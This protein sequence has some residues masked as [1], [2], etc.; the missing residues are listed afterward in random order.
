[1]QEAWNKGQILLTVLTVLQLCVTFTLSVYKS[2]CS[3]VLSRFSHFWYFVTLWTVAHQALL[4]IGFFRQEY[5]S[6]LPLPSL[7]DLPNPETELGLL[8][9]LHWRVGS[10]PLEPTGNSNSF[11]SMTQ[12]Q[13]F[14]FL[15]GNG[16][17]TE[18]ENVWKY[19]WSIK[20]TVV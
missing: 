8:C 17:S 12:F 14:H 11:D 20:Y 15:W 13:D 10:L 3:A 4:A 9:L 6:G 1:M 7:R 2:Q 19:H 16:E 5:W 18:W